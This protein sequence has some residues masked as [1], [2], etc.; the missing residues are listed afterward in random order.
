MI[1]GLGLPWPSKTAVTALPRDRSDATDPM[2]GFVAGFAVECSSRARL[3]RLRH[4]EGYGQPTSGQGPAAHNI[5]AATG[6]CR[7]DAR[8]MA[9]FHRAGRRAPT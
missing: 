5:G 6:W 1:G 9:T 8:D 7:S 4:G 2:G 3:F